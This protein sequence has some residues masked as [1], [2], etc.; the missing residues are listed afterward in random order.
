MLSATR[1]FELLTPKGLAPPTAFRPEKDGALDAKSASM[2]ID[3]EGIGLTRASV[4]NA[5]AADAFPD[6]ISGDIGCAG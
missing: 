3:V 2:P 5:I 6:V 1:V 4:A